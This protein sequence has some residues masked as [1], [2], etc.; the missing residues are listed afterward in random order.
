RRR[1]RATET[2]TQA[3]SISPYSFRLMTMKQ[4]LTPNG[5]H[6]VPQHDDDERSPLNIP[7]PFAQK[8]PNLLRSP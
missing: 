3:K 6:T 8:T 7:E 5:T 4:P 2:A 1:T